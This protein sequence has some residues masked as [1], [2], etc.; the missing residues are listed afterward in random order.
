MVKKKKV[1]GKGLGA[2]LEE[3]EIFDDQKQNLEVSIDH[4][5]P[6]ENQPRKT[7]E[8][9]EKLSDSVKEHGVLQPIVLSE[10][11]KNQYQI[12][13]GERR[14]RASKMA[15]LKTIPAIIKKSVTPKDKLV[16]GLI[17]NIQRENLNPIEEGEAFQEL[18]NK[19]KLSIEQLSRIAGKDRTTVTNTMRLL[20]LPAVI[21][22]DL[23][24]GLYMA[25][26][27]RPLINVKDMKLL[28]SIRKKII[29]EK[30]SVREIEKI[31]Q[32]HK[33]GPV[34]AVP[35]AKKKLNPALKRVEERFTEKLATKVKINGSNAQ[36][37]IV[38]E[39][40]SQ[41]DLNRFLDILN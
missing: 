3:N 32:H 2:L 24:D 35:A 23:K 31:I 17:E 14:W 20:N 28:N 8:G 41:D 34:P 16:L 5:I 36:G 18:M 10:S 27:A 15:G 25:G 29:N 11:G 33:N 9:I 26:H 38:I 7:L 40:Y 12:I 6:N 22:K 30:I 13:A 21:Q 39:Y 4:I 1:L 37:K 19:F